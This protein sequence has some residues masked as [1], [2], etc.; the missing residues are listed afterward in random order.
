VPEFGVTSQVGAPLLPVL[1]RFV[2]VDGREGVAVSAAVRATA[3]WGAVNV[4]PFQPPT[5]RDAT[6]APP[7][8]LDEELYGFDQWWP[9]NVVETADP[10]IVHGRRYVP[11]HYYPVQYNPLRAELRVIHE[12]ELTIA[13]GTVNAVNPLRRALP[14]STAFAPLVED[15]TWRFA[16]DKEGYNFDPVDGAIL[17]I[18]YDDFANGAQTYIDW[19]TEKGLPVEVIKTSTLNGQGQNAQ[20]I[21]GLITKRYNNA[22][23]PPLDYVLLVGDFEHITTLFG[24]GGCSSDSRYV[25]IDG[26]DYFPDVVIGRISVK[27]KKQLANAINKVVNYEREPNLNNTAW[28]LQ[29]LTV[30]SS[31]SQDDQNAQFCGDILEENGYT[32]VDY[33]FESSHNNSAANVRQA[34]NQGRSWISYFGHG[35]GTAWSST[36]PPFSNQHVMDLTN[37]RK[38]PVITDISCDNGHFDASW[39]CFAEVWIKYSETAGAAG[40]FSA[41]RSTPFGWTDQLGRGVTVAHFRRGYLTFGAAAYFGKMYMYE[42]YAEGPG[43]TTEEVFQHYLVFGDPEL[44]LWSDVPAEPTVDHPAEIEEGTGGD[45]TIE[46]LADGAP[47]KRALVHVWRDGEFDAVGRTDAQGRLLVTLDDT[48]APGD[49][50]VRVTGPNLLPYAG[51]IAIVTPPP[52]SDDDDDQTDDDATDDDAADDDQSSD[53]DDDDSSGGCG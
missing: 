23:K 53:D 33:F 39:D 19:K 47:L 24:I 31:Q 49:L 17:V 1:T 25:T 21:K 36:T 16:R 42:R 14:P 30:S 2:E 20:A 15:F 11:V 52:P 8:T 37:N 40:I 41:S 9:A 34:I 10:V 22:Q 6:D 4:L 50:H 28:F 46:V 45:V 44:N 51:T 13:G 48:L 12:V 18:V 27:N 43:G 5:Y 29:G 38:L 35:S 26:N 7:F 3:T 32:H